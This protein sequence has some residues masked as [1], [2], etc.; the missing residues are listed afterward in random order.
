MAFNHEGL[1]V[2]QHL[3]PFNAKIGI[4][5]GEWNGRHAICDQLSRAAG[6]MLENVA[7][8]SAAFSSMI[9]GIQR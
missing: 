9:A 7:M 2:Y 8:A 5:T 3:L 4:W 1:N 6:S